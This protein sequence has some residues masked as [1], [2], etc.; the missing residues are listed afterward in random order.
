MEL[1]FALV[2]GAQGHQ[3]GVVGAGADLAEP[4][5]FAFDKQLHTKQAL[6][7]QVVG[8]RLGDFA[9]ALQ[10][11]GVHLHRL[12]A[13][14]IVATDLHVADGVAKAGHDLAICTDRAHGELGDFVIEIDK[15]FHNDPAVADAA[16]GH[17]VVPC[18]LDIFRAVNFALAFAGAAHHRFDDTGVADALPVFAIDRRLQFG[19]RVAKLVGAGGQAQCFCRQAADAFPVHRQ[20]GGPGGR[21]HAHRACGL[22]LFEHG[23][24][25]GFNFRHHQHGALRFNQCLELRWIAHGDRARVVGHLLTGRVVIAIY[26]NGLDPQ[27]LQCNQH[28]FAQFTAAEQHYFGRMGGERR[29]E[30]GH[31]QEGVKMVR[32]RLS[33]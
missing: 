3:A 4:H 28:F 7:A 24:G 31:G 27:A 14:D 25:N 29:S 33:V 23:R 2:L 5:L 13:F 20:A 18:F 11:G 22:Q 6:P 16:A 9:C 32:M 21:N 12:P 15:P 10:G 1:K 26:R 8:H 19:Q 17:G 30:C